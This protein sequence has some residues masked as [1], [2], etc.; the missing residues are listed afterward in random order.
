MTVVSTPKDFVNS[1]QNQYHVL[2]RKIAGLLGSFGGT[3]VEI[4]CGKGQLTV[5]LAKLLSKWRIEA[6]DSFAYPYSA[7]YKSLVSVV[8]AAG[9]KSR[10]RPVVSDYSKWLKSQQDSTFD[11]VITSEFL[12]ELNYGEMRYFLSECHRIVRPGGISTHSFLS[13]IPKNRWQKLLIEADSDPRWTKTP[14]KQWFSP[15]PQIAAAELRRAGFKAIQTMRM[16][17]NLRVKEEAAKFLLKDWDVRVSFWNAHKASLQRHG[18][19]IP[20][21][22]ILKASK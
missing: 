15:K 22:L 4:G 17:S 21:W 11:S 14:P 3:L 18:L 6:V 19:E 10:I 8:S 1:W 13:P 12:P 2:A 7:D 5:P 16:K 9:L 20:D